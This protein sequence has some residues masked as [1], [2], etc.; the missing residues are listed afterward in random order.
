M[1]PD[2]S[3]FFCVYRIVQ[4]LTN[5]ILNDPVEFDDEEDFARWLDEH[6]LDVSNFGRGEAKTVRHLFDE[7]RGGK[8]T[9]GLCDGSVVRSVVN[10]QIKLRH[11]YKI[12]VEKMQLLEDGRKRVRK[13]G[14]RG[15]LIVVKNRPAEGWRD[16]ARRGLQDELNL[17]A[18]QVD[19][20]DEGSIERKNRT[21]DS[22]S[23]PGV[24]TTYTETH[25]DARLLQDRL[26]PEER[27]RLGL[28]KS[29]EADFRTLKTGRGGTS[30]LY[31]TW[32]SAAVW[33]MLGD[34]AQEVQ[35]DKV[36]FTG[37]IESV[38][39]Q[40]KL[41]KRLRDCNEM[42]MAPN[43]VEALCAAMRRGLI[44]MWEDAKAVE[45][46][47]LFGGR[48]GSLVLDATIRDQNDGVSQV[49]VVK[50]DR[51]KD[52]EEEVEQT[53]HI[54]KH[55]GENAP[56]IL[57]DDKAYFESLGVTVKMGQRTDTSEIGLL[58]IE[59]VGAVWISP[60]FAKLGGKLM[61]TFEELFK[62]ELANSHNSVASSERPV[63]GEVP[64]L[65]S[66]VFSSSGILT[67]VAQQTVK[68]S[69]DNSWFHNIGTKLNR[70]LD[71]ATSV[72]ARN[73]T[74]W[75]RSDWYKQGGAACRE[76]QLELEQFIIEHV[77]SPPEWLAT[78]GVLL[79]LIHGDFHGGNLLVDLR[80]TPWV[81]DYG[82]VRDESPSIFDI[83]RLTAGM[84]FE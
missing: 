40:P 27:Q 54:L 31:W 7:V 24:A 34:D 39:L 37:T 42:K 33:R 82:E 81:I 18:E 74:P 32:E 51:R 41:L 80:G 64:T 30:H 16:A 6:G 72:T 75:S 14:N 11:G 78:S 65:I 46:E 49:C 55:L 22:P 61:C 77:K 4:M 21:V 17:R 70:R 76:A 73:P 20:C 68:R 28:K 48:S 66:D 9:L 60:E 84:L 52:L 79:S 69:N 83:A 2:V 71:E 44:R 59:L 19:L 1:I 36:Q 35:T 53:R 26:T 10:T 47:L 5:N 43:E 45:V 62:W 23:F 57:C 63:Y 12:L 13:D 56:R 15:L 67:G 58:A 25:C 29:G 3:F 8:C 50:V 38:L